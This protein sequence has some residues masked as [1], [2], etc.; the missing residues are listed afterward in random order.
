MIKVAARNKFSQN[1]KIKS[2]R[3]QS[4]INESTNTLGM[5]VNG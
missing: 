4:N 1:G 2:K 5:V 3:N